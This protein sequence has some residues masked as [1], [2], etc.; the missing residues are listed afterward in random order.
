MNDTINNIFSK[1]LV[2]NESIFND[3]SDTVRKEDTNKDNIIE[4]IES[5]KK[6]IIDKKSKK[7]NPFDY[8]LSEYICSIIKTIPSFYKDDF[9]SNVCNKYLNLYNLY[10]K[11]KTIFDDIL[12]SF[13]N[14]YLKLFKLW[15][16]AQ[17]STQQ[18]TQQPNKTNHQSTQQQSTQQVLKE[19][20]KQLKWNNL[21]AEAC[22]NKNFNLIKKALLNGANVNYKT[23]LGY[24]CKNICTTN[25][26]MCV[27]ELVTNGA[28]VNLTT[29]GCKPLHIACGLYNSHNFLT[30]PQIDTIKLLLKTGANVNELSYFKNSPLEIVCGY[31]DIDII[32]LFIDHGANRDCFEKI[33]K[34]DEKLIIDICE[35]LKTLRPI[36][37]LPIFTSNPT[38]QIPKK[39]THQPSTQPKKRP[40][41]WH[42]D[43]Y[44]KKIVKEQP[45]N[46]IP[47]WFTELH[48]KKTIPIQVQKPIQ[49]PV[50]E[51]IQKPV[52]EQT[53]TDLFKK[54][55]KN[56]FE[57]ASFMTKI[58]TKTFEDAFQAGFEKGLEGLEKKESTGNM[59]DINKIISA[60]LK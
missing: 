60:I 10:K 52:P 20:Q 16:T 44:S 1:F 19:R 39:P 42:T 53:Q 25:D 15:D 35:K 30:K 48:S 2:G 28:D 29:L 11:D 56:V 51:P 47:S 57:S 43:V 7:K 31:K 46:N 23:P 6:D 13:L 32:C 18:S 9:I 54:A 5:L 24:L 58:P 50:P 37:Q 27:N 21:F 26:F 38:Q 36:K 55:F 34:H 8:V 40:S 3:T 17:Q 59:D 49:K 12:L 14:V 22:V 4:L 33:R 45:Q 41:H